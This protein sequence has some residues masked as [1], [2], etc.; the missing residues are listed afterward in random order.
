MSLEVLT[1]GL[2]SA[3]EVEQLVRVFFPEAA[4]RA[5]GSSRG[6][7]VLAVVSASRMAAALRCDGRVMVRR[8]ALPADL[9]AKTALSR[10]VYDLLCE[11]T[12][13]RP[14]W[15]MLTGVRPVA[16][17]RKLCAAGGEQAAEQRLRGL[18]DVR[19][20][21][22]ELARRVEQKQRPILAAGTPA[23]Y[24]LY[25]S[26]PFCPTRCDYCSFV[27][28]TIEREGHL[29]E[30]Y[31]AAL[32]RE[33][34][35]TAALV[36]RHG[37]TPKAL[38]IGGGTPTSLSAPQ[39]EGL[40]RSVQRHFPGALFPEYTV[41]AGRPD[42][43][44]P[45]KLALI[46][47]YGATRISINPQTM[48]D[49]V[50]RRIGRRHTGGD[51]RRCFEDARRAGH[52]NINMD[53]IAGLPGDTEQGFAQS[54]E[55]VASLGPE[56]ITLHT[57]TLKRASNLVVEGRPEVTSPMRMVEGAYPALER[58][59]YEPYYMY[60]Q[61]STVENLE[62]TGWTKPGFPGLYNVH[63]MEEQTTILAV[64]AGAVTKLVGAAEGRIQRQ[65]NYK[66][67]AE[68]IKN[69]DH[70]MEKKKGVEEFYA[71]NLDTQETG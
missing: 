50:L 69:F 64:G 1:K 39:L 35:W 6:E 42:C 11:A 55:Q 49:E 17:Y 59:G 28:Q 27:S 63:I 51:V 21:K 8:E 41:E 37:L 62:N 46:R 24:C 40:L 65:Y 30:P 58:Q 70:M 15:G 48:S 29:I 66:L 26:I 43:T 54:L 16:F 31:L 5:G 4:P 10:L 25:I 3:Y 60:R 56:N 34:A 68:Y 67:P 61:K 9:P 36:E 13:K 52:H 33:L 14:P 38:Y 32:E 20:E 12:G 7:L 53:L 18:Y 44:G 71:G 22:F 57:L 45:E 47:Q 23:D 19:P 2:P